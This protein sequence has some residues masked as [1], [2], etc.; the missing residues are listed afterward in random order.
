MIPDLVDFVRAADPDVTAEELADVL[1]LARF[2]SGGPAA[3]GTPAS[4]PDPPGADREPAAPGEPLG[5][6]V[7][8]PRPPVVPGHAALR[9]GPVGQG[10]ADAA[11]G[12]RT[13]SPA[14]AA[15]PD[16]PALSRAL[17]PLRRKVPSTETAELDESATADHI[18]D[19]GL[20]L[21]RTRPG[22]ER[23]LD[24]ALVVDDSASM[25]V[26]ERTITEFRAVLR[27]LGAFRDVRTWRFDGDT[28]R[29]VRM[30]LH[31]ATDSAQ[32]RPRELLDPTGRRLVLVVS[33]CVGEAWSNGTAAA[34]LAQWGAAGPVAVVQVLP[35]RLWEDCGPE[36]VR[37]R[38]RGRGPGTPNHRLAVRAL[39]PDDDLTGAGVPIPVLELEPRW[40]GPWASM[41]VDS[42]TGWFTG[43]ALF[44]GRMDR[45]REEPP[46]APTADEHLRR[47]RLRASTTAYRLAVY[48]ACAPLSLPVMRLVQH[49]M[50][51]SSRPAHLAEVFLSGLLRHTAEDG[52]DLRFDFQPGVRDELLSELTRHEALQVLSKV[53]E[54]VT[55]RLGS[56]FDFR[57]LLT[58]ETVDAGSALGPPFAKVARDVLQ[59]LGGRYAEVARRLRV[60]PTRA[61][62]LSRPAHEETGHD[63]PV[64]NAEFVGR[65]DLL[66]A[67]RRSLT[68]E[69]PLVLVGFGGM[70][71]TQLAIEYAH[72][73]RDDYDLV[74]WVPADD[75]AV[76]RASLADLGARMG[77]P[78]SADVQRTVDGVLE[79]LRTTGRWL[80]V[81]DG[82][83]GPGGLRGLLPTD[84]HVVVTSRSLEWATQA[85]VL[86]IGE[87]TRSDSVTLLL[88]KVSRL[89]PEEADRVAAVLHDHP[90]AVRH[91]AA[92]LAETDI[93]AD[94]YV[95]LLAQQSSEPREPWTVSIRALRSHAPDA[96]V[97]LDLCAFFADA[98]IPIEV[99]EAGRDL[100]TPFGDVLGNPVR[101]R[102]ALEVLDRV[103]LIRAHFAVGRIQ[104]HGLVQ[105]SV[106]TLLR[107]EDQPVT[108]AHART[109]LGAAN[110]GEPDEPQNWPRYR[111]LAPHIAAARLVGAQE[112]PAR[113]LVLDHIRHLF[114]IGD[115]EGSRALGTDTAEQWRARWGLDEELTLL[116]RRLVANAIRETGHVAEAMALDEDTVRRLTEVFG[117]DHEHTLMAAH[118]LGA[119][120]RAS[121]R[122]D[123]AVQL[124]RTNL[125]RHRRKWGDNHGRTLRA[126]INLAVDLRLLGDFA[127]AREID[128][129]VV[130]RRRE[131]YGADDPRTLFAT[132]NLVRDLLG[133][134]AY[135]EALRIQEGVLPTLR[136]ALGPD[137]NHV[138]LATRNLVIALRGTGRYAQARATGEENL[139]ACERRLGPHHEY[140]LAAM[141]TLCNVLRRTGELEYAQNLGQRA[142]SAHMDRHPDPWHPFTLAS[143][144]NLALVWRDIGKVALAHELNRT[145]LQASRERRGDD[146]PHTLAC[147]VNVSSDLAALGDHDR[148]SALSATTLPRMARVLGD[149]HPHTLICA[150]N[151]AL[152]HIATGRANGTA[153]AVA[154]LARRL[155][156]R[157]PEV[158]L[159][160]AGRRLA[161][162]V[163]PPPT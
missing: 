98:P 142:Y 153:E 54:F 36:F 8:P 132:A 118:G 25:V 84:G 10:A 9:V 29:G 154:A 151:S 100:P 130:R 143:A 113:L 119:D 159:A 69:T 140:T 141:M 120:L 71:K 65:D 122:F 95:G 76:V 40:F 96:A 162:D 107:P 115:Y 135:D 30:A 17:R 23:W 5:P 61:E 85:E 103:A 81:F 53:S 33:D 87:L 42:G 19:T 123:S 22:A 51:P 127:G 91:A 45:P 64:R 111:A 133:L 134:G 24:L 66:D 55:H 124:D 104:V 41:V 57:A 82:A 26:W 44:T 28:G 18:A 149:Q 108:M 52:D 131:M 43:A 157:H 11:E 89:T 50:L 88:G 94:T 138:L 117:A 34:A 32:H 129:D 152:D 146:H 158:V 37:V 12:V 80:L 2:L 74:W 126:A 68:E 144:T 150:F 13:R 73:F 58:E 155:G 114:A 160:A 109:V 125:D 47:F 97:V 16:V 75:P 39:D 35:Q 20:W 161:C 14:V 56:P 163:E 15:L 4:R 48:L 38:L 156:T 101:L 79:A 78:A 31:G 145:T 102:G 49:A 148:A 59:R 6:P 3:P 121:G 112:R 147:A 27:Q 21:P 90:L 106:R 67:M 86:L 136:S 63:L 77:L 105:H 1:W 72:R 92:W 128:L 137:H 83:G 46:P 62:A 116:A 110:P 139:A 93:P 70:G 7:T 60:D 99:L